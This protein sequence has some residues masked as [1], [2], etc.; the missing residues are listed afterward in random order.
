MNCRQVLF[1]IDDYPRDRLDETTQE[2]IKKHIDGCAGCRDA[3]QAIS[4][5]YDLLAGDKIDDPGDTYWNNFENRVVGRLNEQKVSTPGTDINEKESIE[6]RVTG[7]LLPLAAS[8][9]LFFILTVS[10][11]FNQ[12]DKITMTDRQPSELMQYAIKSSASQLSTVLLSPPGAG[13]HLV[14]SQLK[15]SIKSDEDK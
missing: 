7:Y 5:W 6:V 9:T 11:V 2:E 10:G 14:L 15:K 3:A 4:E 13:Q 12:D 1:L 8:I